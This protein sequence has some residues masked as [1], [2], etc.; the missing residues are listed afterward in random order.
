MTV[1]VTGPDGFIGRALVPT[2]EAA[3]F[4]VRRAG[5]ETTGDIARPVD[6]TPFLEG[7]EAVVHLAARVHVL[8]EEASDPLSLYRRVNRDGTER[9]AAAAAAAGVRR[10]ILLSTVKVH[11]ENARRPLT[12]ADPPA[13]QDAYAV[14]KWEAEQALAAAGAGMERV[15]LRSPLVYGPGVGGNFL[16]LL[17]LVDRAPVL[18]FGAIDNRRSLIYVAN[19]ADAIRHAI[20]N[21]PPGT[22]L[23]SDGQDLSTAELVRRLARALGRQVRLAPIPP[24]LLAFAGRLA[25]RAEEVERLIGSLVVDGRIPGWKPP[26]PADRG[27]ARTAEW[28]RC[29]GTDN[30]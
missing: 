30:A 13:P 22:Y 5:R 23:P 2:L 11:G 1:L 8:R 29:A 20:T 9:L 27:L 4:A 21:A 17:R 6:W 15:V 7:V 25:G 26:V 28:Y 19:L 16:R 10:F 14:S 3:G 24:A 18:P 12:P